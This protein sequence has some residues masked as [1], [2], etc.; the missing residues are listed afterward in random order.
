MSRREKSRLENYGIKEKLLKAL[1]IV[2]LNTGMRICEICALK[3]E[4]IN[5]ER[6]TL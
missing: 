1:E 4:E 6:R 5:L 2:C 3:W